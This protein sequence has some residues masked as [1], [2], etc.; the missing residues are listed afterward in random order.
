MRAIT[1]CWEISLRAQ[2]PQ[3][4][5]SLE[6]PQNPKRQVS[7]MPSTERIQEPVRAHWSALL[8]TETTS[9]EL[10][11]RDNRWS[12]GQGAGRG[13]RGMMTNISLTVWGERMCSCQLCQCPWWKH[14]HFTTNFRYQ[15]AIYQLAKDSW[16]LNHPVSQ[17]NTLQL[18]S[19]YQ[20]IL[21]KWIS[22]LIKIKSDL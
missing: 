9:P 16:T 10:N 22:L 4:R 1:G 18:T 2:L 5:Y 6:E 11:D 14:A 7:Q 20:F 13:A 15:L 19:E 12:L 17:A 3:M 21:A 8:T